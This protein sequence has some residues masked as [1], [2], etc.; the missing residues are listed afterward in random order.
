MSFLQR[1]WLKVEAEM[2][3]CVYVCVCVV[4]PYSLLFVAAGL[5]PAPLDHGGR[6]CIPQLPLDYYC[7]DDDEPRLRGADE[8]RDNARVLSVPITT[9]VRGG[10]DPANAQGALSHVE[11]SGG[12]GEIEGALEDAL[13]AGRLEL[14]VYR[15]GP[16][17]VYGIRSVGVPVYGTPVRLGLDDQWHG[18]VGTRQRDGGDTGCNDGRRVNE[19]EGIRVIHEGG[20]GVQVEGQCPS[21]GEL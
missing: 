19:A 18:A 1:E 17:Q 9:G 15:A 8:G 3:T 5:E 4:L 14:D 16:G 10:L 12:E 11:E 7:H 2:C 6:V 20:G 21:G 13:L